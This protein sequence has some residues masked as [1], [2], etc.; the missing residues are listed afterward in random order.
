MLSGQAAAL[1]PAE[2]IRL[3]RMHLPKRAEVLG[4]SVR[5]ADLA[6]H[7]DG[8]GGG[9]LDTTHF[10]TVRFPPPAWAA[11]VMASAIADGSTAYTPYRGAPEVLAGLAPVLT[12]FLGRPVDS[13]NIALT[14]GTQAG[15]FTTLAAIV[16]E[17][18]LV[19]L[20]D[21]EYLFVERMLEFL[22]ARVERIRV[23]QSAS[24][25]AI[26]L[27]RI[28]ELLPEKPVLFVYSHPNNP[29]GSVF[30]PA[31][32]EAVAELSALGGFRVLAD[33]L[34]SRLV[35][36]GTEYRHMSSI[37]GMAERTITML[38]PS[39]TESLSGFRLGVVVGPHD[40]MDAVEQT[41]AATSLRAPAYA[42]RLL[43]HWLI[44]DV[45]FVATR[46]EEL[47]VLRDMTVE[48]FR[49]VPGLIVLPGEGT[50]YLFADVTAFGRTDQEIAGA[51][52]RDA[53]VIVSPGYQFGPSGIGHFRVC[54]A[55]D[56]V[57]WAATL[58]RMVEV[59]TGLGADA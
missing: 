26:D 36:P 50:A 7:L 57:E 33:E 30:T 41:L 51:L 4:Q 19:L 42:Q 27:A 13:R 38:G 43:A 22:G 6:L 40:V 58:E 25:P 9:L 23:G 56:E 52:K 29:T 2:S 1:R 11:S 24:G 3:R 54:Y 5:D 45:D 17:G 8:G 10:D 47:A 59:L 48:A 20:A 12:E 14:P 53:G 35:Y 16:D 44:E 31:T 21:P 46:I 34:Y 28:E 55:R 18:D 32:L 37:P 39:K 49:R 15:L